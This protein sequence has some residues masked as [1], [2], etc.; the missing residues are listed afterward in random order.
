MA[1]PDVGG[2]SVGPDP[3]EMAMTLEEF[4]A[5]S[6]QVGDIGGWLD[7]FRQLAAG[8]TIIEVGVGNANSSSAWLIGNPKS[9]WSVDLVPMPRAYE[10]K[11]I[12]PSWSYNEGDSVRREPHAPYDV[13]ILFIDSEH[14]FDTTLA[15]LRAYSP[16][17]R[18]G[19]LILLH[20][21][22]DHQ[23]GVKQAIEAF[24]AETGRSW[25]N[26]TACYGLGTIEW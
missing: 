8:K 13:D 17:V 2:D 26:S 18:P 11:K 1:G 5:G 4:Y 15:E 7:H 14:S 19:G 3:A 21:T 24:C 23:P 6:C 25:S 16:H 12:V 22:G 9:L 10:L 20:D